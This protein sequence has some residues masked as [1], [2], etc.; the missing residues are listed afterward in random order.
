MKNQDIVSTFNIVGKDGQRYHVRPIR[1][2]DAASLMRG[3][4][5]MSERGKWFRMLHAV[6]HLTEAMAIRFCTPDPCDE[7]CLIIEGREHLKDDILG[8]ARV[9][10]L[11]N[12]RKAEFSVSLR[13]EVRGLGLA[14]QALQ[15][16]LEIAR[17]TGCSIVLGFIAS[18]NEPMLHLAKKCGFK[19]RRDPDDFGLFIAEL[20][21]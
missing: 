7:I 19:L 1:P 16:V 4:D 15:A 20:S 5:A 10:G 3:Y 13:P 21:F 12:G 6:P 11:G 14:K 2:T 17:R 9:S 8:G 18:E